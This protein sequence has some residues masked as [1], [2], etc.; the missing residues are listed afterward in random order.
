MKQFEKLR[1]RLGRMADVHAA[2]AVL[3]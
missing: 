3:S 2:Q 1:E